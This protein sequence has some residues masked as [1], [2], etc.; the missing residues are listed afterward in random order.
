MVYLSIVSIMSLSKIT[1]IL[2]VDAIFLIIKDAFCF[3][4]VVSINKFQ[5]WFTSQSGPGTIPNGLYAALWIGVW[6]G[7]L[8]MS[9]S[10]PADLS[11]Q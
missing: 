2:S 1:Q 10:M 9:H 3:K 8:N 7:F 4:L 5:A 11:A 6:D